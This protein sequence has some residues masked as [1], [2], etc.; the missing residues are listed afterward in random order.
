[1]AKLATAMDFV[2]GLYHYAWDIQFS[3]QVLPLEGV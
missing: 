3:R 2:F 1:M